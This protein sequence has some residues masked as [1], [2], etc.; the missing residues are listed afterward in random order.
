MSAYQYMLQTWLQRG[1]RF[2]P[3]H[4]PTTQATHWG[5]GIILT[6][7]CATG[8]QTIPVTVQ[9]CGGQILSQPFPTN[10][11]C[12]L[13]WVDNFLTNFFTVNV[14][15]WT[16]PSGVQ[17]GVTV[18]T[19][20]MGGGYASTFSNMLAGSAYPAINM[21]MDMYSFDPTSLTLYTSTIQTFHGVAP[22]GPAHAV[23][24]EE[25]GPQAWNYTPTL[26]ATAP[27]GEACAIVGLQSCT[28]NTFN[29]NFFASLLSFLSSQ[30]VTDASLYG[31]EALGACAP[32]YPDNG[33]DPNALF[34][35]TTA[36]QN[37]QYSL[38]GARLSAIL[39][40]WNTT[41]VSGCTLIGASLK[42]K[43]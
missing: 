16:I 40:A 18:N 9:S 41:G 1:D 17:Y 8:T 6:V 12:P 20:E 37:R 22:P 10:N 34:A 3:V 14:Q 24:A 27:T 31:T 39:A 30:G 7:G 19:L 4:E 38:S 33:Q 35:A 21:G 28:W 32:L 5:E 2:V 43:P 42:A 25:Y 29:Q 23:F 11:T 13:D 36:M 15:S 26:P